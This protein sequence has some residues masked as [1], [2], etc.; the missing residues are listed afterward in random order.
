MPETRLL[1]NLLDQ[2]NDLWRGRRR[3][4]AQAAPSGR[5]ELDAWLPDGGWPHGSLIE[6]LPE[7]VGS[8]ELDL[9]VPLLAEQTRH[10]W[11]VLLVAPPL[12]PC[13]QRLHRAGIA[14]DR[15]VIVRD[16]SQALWAAEQALKSGVCG[17]IVTWHP[18]GR[19]DAR[20]IRRLQLAAREGS[21]PAFV[22][23]CPGQVPPPSLA[24]LRLGIRPGPILSLLRGS[25]P[26]RTLHLGRGN[27]IALDRRRPQPSA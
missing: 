23:Y 3:P 27:V 13:P 9:L 24:A 25:G 26:E 11:P 20:P 22:C 6:L 18:R 14:L 21:A 5:A 17:S 2:R 4:S 19:V 16:S 12:I 15:L 1:Q 10:G 8:G 7:H